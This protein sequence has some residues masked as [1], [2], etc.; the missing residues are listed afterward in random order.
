M[1]K[2][3]NKVIL[4]I[5]DMPEDTFGYV[6][7][8]S[9]IPTGKKYIGKKVLYFNR[10]LPPLK[11]Y[12]RKRKVTKESDWK[13]YYGS[14]PYIKDIV[15]NG[16]QEELEREI[17]MYCNTKK[18]LTYWENYYLFTNNVLIDD[19]YFNDNIEGRYYR[20]DFI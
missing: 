17:L 6:Y 20:K 19:D 5:E 4:S 11:G 13:T 18:L 14:H 8:T 9:H 15:S 10:T 16:L 2:H 1:I 12:K 7:L 3:Q